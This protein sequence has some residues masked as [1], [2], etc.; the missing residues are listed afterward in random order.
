MTFLLFTSGI[1]WDVRE[2]GS[3]EKVELILALNPIAFML[4]A[5]RQVLMYQT[6]PDVTHLFLIG[7]GAGVLI[8]LMV[9]LMRKYSQYLAL[10]V[11]T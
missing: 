6:T 2:I 1:F 9:G 10:K 4:D 3:P 11:L 7:L 8:I 5:H